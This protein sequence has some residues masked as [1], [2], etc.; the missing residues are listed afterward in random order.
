MPNILNHDIF[1]RKER[2]LKPSHYGIINVVTNLSRNRTTRDYILGLRYEF[3]KV[4]TTG[5][6]A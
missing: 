3:K 2:V 6:W 5:E 1:S 4:M